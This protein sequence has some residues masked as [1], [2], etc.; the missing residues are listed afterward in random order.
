MF[1]PLGY[2]YTYVMHTHCL[3]NVVSGGIEC[4]EAVLIRALEP[5][6]GIDLMYQRSGKEKRN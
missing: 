1:G 4:L 5:C 6:C 3:V 2:A